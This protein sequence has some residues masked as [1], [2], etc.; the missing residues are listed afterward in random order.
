MPVTKNNYGA[1]THYSGTIAEV[2][3]EL[4]RQHASPGRVVDYIDDGTDAKAVV[5]GAEKPA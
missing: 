1:F 4:S 3:A 2:L 5:H